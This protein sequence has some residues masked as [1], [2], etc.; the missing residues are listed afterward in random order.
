[1]KASNTKQVNNQVSPS[2]ELHVIKSG[3]QQAI[4]KLNNYLI[5]GDQ[6]HRYKLEWSKGEGTVVSSVDGKTSSSYYRM[7]L[8]IHEG[9]GLVIPIYGGNYPVP[10]TSFIAITEIEIQA[11]KDLLIHGIGHLIS[12]QHSMF[13]Q[14][15]A[16][17]KEEE[18]KAIAIEKDAIDKAMSK[19]KIIKG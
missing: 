19:S 13:L 7:D 3:V 8:S 17:E 14:N 5:A 16:R 18:Q 6:T 2:V 10:S 15:E 9:D 4:T 1:M 11:Y 12:V